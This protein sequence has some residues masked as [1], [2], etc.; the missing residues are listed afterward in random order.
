MAKATSASGKGKG[1]G[2]KKPSSQS[3]P[4]R[5][6]AVAKPKATRK[7]RAARAKPPQPGYTEPWFEEIVHGLQEGFALYDADG[8]LVIAN[9]EYRRL[10][11]NVRDMIKPGM[12]FED[13]VRAFFEGGHVPEAV[14]QEEQFIQERLR[15]HR[16]PA[17]SILRRKDDGT[18]FLIQ[19]SRLPGNEIVV[20]E[21]DVTALTEAQVAL[22]ESQQ[23]FQDFAYVG[24]DWL[25]EMDA[26]L[27]FVEF[28]AEDSTGIA[29]AGLAPGRTHWDLA[30]VDPAQDVNWRGHR[31]DLLAHRE[32][33]DFEY[34]V[35]LGESEIRHISVSGLP[36]FGPDDTFLGYRG[37]ARDITSRIRADQIVEGRNKVLELLASGASLDGVLNALVTGMEGAIPGIRCSV[38]LST[39]DG[40]HLTCGAAPNL[41]DFYNEAVDGIEIGPTAGCCGAAAYHGERVV[42]EDILTHPNWDAFRE[43]ATR[44]G[45]RACWA[46]PIKSSDGKV[47]GTFAVYYDRPMRPDKFSLDYATTTAYLA[48]IAIESKAKET[49]LVIAK[50][51]AEQANRTKSQFLANMSHELRTPMNAILGFSEAISQ[52]VLGTVSPPKYKEYATDIHRSAEH[53]LSL[54]N[55]ILDL[56]RI[57]AGKLELGDHEEIDV[58][59]LI[60][61]CVQYFREAAYVGD[62]GIGKD[63]AHDLPGLRGDRRACKQI[64]FNLLS[65][66]V[67]FTPQGGRIDV[68]VRHS[69]IGSLVI[70]VVDTGIG[71]PANQIEKAMK[72]FERVESE[73][74][75]NAEGTGLG[76]PIVKS[77]V[78]LQG[79]SLLLESDLGKGTTVTVTFP[80]GRLVSNGGESQS[81]TA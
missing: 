29:L 80:A 49:E 56:S 46:E 35:D 4:K 51:Q 3:V 20:T 18:C 11:G 76:L 19:E 21:T 32:F 43:V 24:S 44:A 78:G 25:W 22:S 28:I 75:R 41:P 64:L 63:C 23:R 55:D 40:K 58:A 38:L 52:E 33:R 53:L 62:I 7:P 81:S 12:R 6:A 66:A 73:M 5:R 37:T 42:S 68:T 70:T 59:D 71:I 27:R 74:V 2:G 61:D 45:L 17:G 65:N 26:L 54:L 47:L 72:P 8:C 39:E 10:H 36:V 60:G 79:G 14:G 16:N 57:E 15:R 13:M 77:L 30:G 50:D 1:K 34:S 31:D 69:D 9:D 48:G 67:K